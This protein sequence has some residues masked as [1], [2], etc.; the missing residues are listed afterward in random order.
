MSRATAHRTLVAVCLAAAIGQAHALGGLILIGSPPKE[1]STLAIGPSVAVYPEAPGSDQTTVLPLL[2]VDYYAASGGFVSTDVGA[3]WNFSRTEGLQYGARLWPI[4]GRHDDNSRA[5]G[6]QDIGNRI[7]GALFMNYAPWE[8]MTL[9]SNLL[10]GSGGDN[11]GVQ[12][13]A[14]TTI[15]AR[16]ASNFVM[17]VMLGATWANANHLRSYYGVTP[18]ESAAGGLPAFAP[19]AGLSDVNYGLVGSL[20]FS[21]QWKLSG[22]WQ[23]ARLMGDAKDSPVTLSRTQN[24]FSLTLWYQFK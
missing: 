8:F 16:L 22:Q 5:R 11:K 20:K 3:G 15:G 13:E 2:G 1:G 9:Q 18:Q 14:G 19:S 7:G 12:F 6:L 4:F 24:T 21:E 23:A 10:A 17:G